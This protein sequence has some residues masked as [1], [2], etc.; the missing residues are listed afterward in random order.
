MVFFIFKNGKTDIG[1][2]S[3]N[4]SDKKYNITVNDIK[5]GFLKEYFSIFKDQKKGDFN[6]VITYDGFPIDDIILDNIV[7]I[8]NIDWVI[9]EV[10]NEVDWKKKS[11]LKRKRENNEEENEQPKKKQKIV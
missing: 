9:F 8:D 10:Y 4:I 11:S 1:I 7:E 3:I 2:C 6:Y 5:T